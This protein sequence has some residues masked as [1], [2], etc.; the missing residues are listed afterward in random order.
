M[1]IQYNSH[2]RYMMK[3]GGVSYISVAII[4]LALLAMIMCMWIGMRQ[5]VWFD[6]AYSILVARHT[7]AE[8]VTLAAAD[9]HPPGYYLLLHTWGSLVGWSEFALRG[10]SVVA[11]GL[12]LILASLLVRRMFGW[13]AAFLSAVLLCSAPLLMRYGFEIRMYSIASLIGI[14]ATYLMVAA[15]SARSKARLWLWAG[16]S[17]LV[18]LGMYTLYYL[19]LLWIAHLAWLVYLHRSTLT[20]VW[21]K[22]WLWAYVGSVVMFLPWLSSFLSQVNNGA[23]AS[24]GQPVNLEQLLGVVSFNTVYKPL[25]Q[26]GVPETILMIFALIAGGLAVVRAYRLTVNTQYI[27]LLALY[28]TVP[29]VILMGVSLFRPMYVERYLSHVAIGL[30]MLVAC[31]LAIVWTA[32]RHSRRS[33][34]IPMLFVVMFMAGCLQLTNVGNFNFQRM[35]HPAVDVVAA[36]I[37]SCSRQTTV[38]AADPYVATELSYYLSANCRQTFYH[39]SAHLGGGYAPFSMS[40]NRIDSTTILADTP[41]VQ[42]VYYG[43]PILT[44]DTAYQQIKQFSAG[45]MTLATYEKK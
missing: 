45:S 35:Q 3:H 44:V 16:Y 37:G 14:A 5:S 42:Y 12:S 23:L 21:R 30:V 10:L 26:L 33:H 31:S 38:V 1:R 13:R 25:W 9:T 19:A 22:P 2:M 43:E 40:P 41:V 27:V 39:D 18:A 36:A 8:I 11:Y 6:E 28:I 17:V 15:C 32:Q 34:V 20:T 7:P 24:I 4:A 29:V